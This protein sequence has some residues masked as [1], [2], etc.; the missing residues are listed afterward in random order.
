LAPFHLAGLVLAEGGEVALNQSAVLRDIRSERPRSMGAGGAPALL[1]SS[2]FKGFSCSLAANSLF[3][4]KY[5]LFE[6][7]GNFTLSQ[8]NHCVNLSSAGCERVRIGKIPC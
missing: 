7:V 5:S 1:L 8:Q 2:A 4:K 6:R 3:C